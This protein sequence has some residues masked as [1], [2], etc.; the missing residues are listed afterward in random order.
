M[1]GSQ[2]WT[3]RFLLD[4]RDFDALEDALSYCQS[5]CEQGLAPRTPFWADAKDINIVRNKLLSFFGPRERPQVSLPHLFYFQSRYGWRQFEIELEE[6]H[7]MALDSMLS[8]YQMH[9]QA[10]RAAGADWKFR[11]HNRVID[12][13]RRC[14]WSSSPTTG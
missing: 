10:Q 14:A 3:Y 9:C 5:L 12:S 2:Q 6:Q 8:C 1:S 13:I 7:M 4:G 11:A